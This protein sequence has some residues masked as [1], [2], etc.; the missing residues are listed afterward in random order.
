MRVDEKEHAAIGHEAVLSF[1]PRS[2][3][4]LL[5]QAMMDHD[6]DFAAFYTELTKFLIE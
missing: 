3:L 6:R 2:H 4:S 5:R 1:V